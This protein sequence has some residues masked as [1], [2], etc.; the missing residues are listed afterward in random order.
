MIEIDGGVLPGPHRTKIIKRGQPE[1]GGAALNLAWHL[2][3]LGHLTLLLGACGISEVGALEVMLAGK[4]ALLDCVARL[5]APT[6]ALVMFRRGKATRSFYLSCRFP[7]SV[8]DHWM[9]VAASCR[10]VVFAGS[11]HP[12][13]RSA[14][15]SLLG[16][17]EKPTVIFAPSYSVYALEFEE[18][19]SLLEGACVI[20]LN[21]HEDLF[22]REEHRLGHIL[23]SQ[24]KTLIVTRDA[25]GAVIRHA[26]ESYII[27]SYSGRKRDVLGAGEAFLA[28]YLHKHMAAASAPIAGRY[29]ALAAA[30]V[31]R[32]RK[33]REILDVDL[34]EKQLHKIKPLES[35]SG[36]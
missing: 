6:D 27:P 36:D 24:E 13:L 33:I 19:R 28:G 11:R 20:A 29:A 7:S 10:W 9:A 12:E 2:T 34:L 1:I 8:I 35:G 21:R 25:D 14:F 31:V 30:S 18:L 15:I 5:E 22:V 4:G 16:S 23:D 17:P 32:T 26:N 3:S